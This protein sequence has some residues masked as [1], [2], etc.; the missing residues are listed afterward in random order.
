MCVAKRMHQGGGLADLARV[1]DGLVHVGCCCVGIAKYPQGPRP[2]GQD[3]HPDV[4]PKSH[5][6]WTMHS[7]IVKR[8]CSIQVWSTFHDSSRKQQRGA[9]HAMS[10]HE[11]NDGPL[12]FSKRQEMGREIAT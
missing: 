10:D 12:A 7:R 11:R 9:H 4:L 5:P 3:R 8:H 1:S 6:Q 2:K